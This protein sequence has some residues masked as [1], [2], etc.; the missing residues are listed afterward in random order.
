MFSGFDCV[1]LL[2]G[3]LS[4]L[5][6]HR[7]IDRLNVC[8]CGPISK[9]AFRIQE[10]ARYDSKHYVRF[11]RKKTIDLWRNECL[12]FLW[13]VSHLLAVIV[14][15]ADVIQNRNKH[16]FGKKIVYIHR[17]SRFSIWNNLYF[18]KWNLLSRS[19]RKKFPFDVSRRLREMRR[20]NKHKIKTA[21]LEAWP[22]QANVT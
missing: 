15:S 11:I 16:K 9:I 1:R 17:F 12:L 10:T 18:S 8:Q 2:S 20:I 13:N 5:R 19:V 6:W 4:P 7:L 21:P 22:D 3:W 14:H